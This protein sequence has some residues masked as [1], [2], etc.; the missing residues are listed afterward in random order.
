[1]G[2]TCPIQFTEAELETHMKAGE[3]WNEAQEFW[4]SVAGLLT[5]DGW[6]PIDR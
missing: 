4:G 6:T 2:V 1:M 5:R 3:G